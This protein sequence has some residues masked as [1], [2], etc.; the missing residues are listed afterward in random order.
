MAGGQGALFEVAGQPLAAWAARALV[1]LPGVGRVAVVAPVVGDEDP[2]WIPAGALVV[3]AGDSIVQNLFRGVEALAS[4]T[5]ELLVVAGDA[6]LISVGA[7]ERFV[8]VCRSAGADFGYPI[9]P[10]EACEARF[11]GVRRTYVRLREGAFTGGNC[12]Y[13]A[14]VA[15]APAL[16]RLDRVF[17]ARKRPAQLARM[18]GLGLVVRLVLGRATVAEAE[19]AADRLLGVR[20]RGIVCAQDPEIGVDVDKPSDLEL[21]RRLLVD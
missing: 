16:E 18:L 19:R 13:L 3:A 1:A 15:V 2:T 12:F 20:T 5:D 11:P 9:V 8:A 10:R 6:P 7:L 17:R 4:P 14:P 21:V